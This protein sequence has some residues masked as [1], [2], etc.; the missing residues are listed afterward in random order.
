MRGARPTC[1]LLVGDKAG[2]K[3]ELTF[4]AWNNQGPLEPSP[5][6]SPGRGWLLTM[7]ALKQRAG[8]AGLT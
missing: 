2:Q 1:Y 5:H 4:V 3:V 6:P 7:F 8:R